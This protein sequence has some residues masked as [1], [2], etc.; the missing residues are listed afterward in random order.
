[1]QIKRGVANN[2][3]FSLFVYFLVAPILHVMRHGQG[4][5]SE[6]V[7]PNGHQIHDPWLTPTGQ[8]Q[9]RDR[10]DRFQRHGE[11]CGLLLW[12]FSPT[13]QEETWEGL[14]GCLFD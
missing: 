6:A 2:C 13:Y 8:Q 5:H 7:S 9:C 1:M 12:N 11:V 3:V 4:W 10:C 14:V